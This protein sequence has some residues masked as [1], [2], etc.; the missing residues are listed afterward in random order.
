M[1]ILKVTAFEAGATSS[2]LS[3][4]QGET[5]GK[6]FFRLSI[7]IAAQQELFGRPLDPAKDAISLL[8][9]DDLKHYHLMG[10]KIVEMDDPT[11]LGIKGGARD[12][13]FLKVATWRPTEG[14]R[15][16]ASLAIINAQVN[17]GGISVKLPD[18]ARPVPDRAAGVR[19]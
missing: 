2:G 8:L 6:T 13:V 3:I 1:G 5:R 16:A 14:K 11:G 9:T 4:S 19:G 12:S 15:P 17:G 7:T 18:W 10:I